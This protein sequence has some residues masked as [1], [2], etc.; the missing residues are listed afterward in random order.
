[1]SEEL[2]SITACYDIT[3]HAFVHTAFVFSLTL[4]FTTLITLVTAWV[5]LP[6][7][8]H[9]CECPGYCCVDFS[10]V[11]ETDSDQGSVTNGFVRVNNSCG[12]FPRAPE[13]RVSSTV[14]LPEYHT[15]AVSVNSD[16]D[17][18]DKS[19]KAYESTLV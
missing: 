1:M 19:V 16:N 3:N 18:S 7:Y 4:V 17:L 8:E 14:S 10:E 11:S 15:V 9:T 13:L 12:P 2:Y 6:Y 5:C